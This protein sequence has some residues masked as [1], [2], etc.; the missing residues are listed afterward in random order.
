MTWISHKHQYHTISIS[1]KYKFSDNIL[2]TSILQECFFFTDIK[3]A[4][5]FLAKPFTAKYFINS[6][7]CNTVHQY[8]SVLAIAVNKY[9]WIKFWGGKNLFAILQLFSTIPYKVYFMYDPTDN[10]L[11]WIKFSKFF[12]ELCYLIQSDLVLDS[13]CFRFSS[14]SEFS[15]S[16]WFT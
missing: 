9:Q 4:S 2:N 5:T 12:C 15:Y 10:F 8:S 14:S 6:Q 11:H 13:S 7:F 16:S 3:Y 1:I